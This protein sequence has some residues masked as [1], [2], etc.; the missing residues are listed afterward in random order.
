[1]LNY[2]FD[3]FDVYDLAKNKNKRSVNGKMY[4][5][6]KRNKR[7]KNFSDKCVQYPIDAVIYALNDKKPKSKHD[8]QE[9]LDKML[10]IRDL[11]IKMDILEGQIQEN[12]L[13][14]KEIENINNK[15][16]MLFC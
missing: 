10:K 9:Y 11:Q 8:E 13:K 12:I 4:F 1:M 2:Y 6:C 7:R 15:L 5:Y 14:Q 3:L 16:K